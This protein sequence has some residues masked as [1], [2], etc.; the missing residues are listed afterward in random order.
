M[1]ASPK[2]AARSSF[3]V[4]ART[5]IIQQFPPGQ[6]TRY[7]IVGLVNTAFGYGIYAALTALLTPHIPFAYMAAS[8]VSSL[9][10]ITFAFFTYKLFIFKTTGNYLR[11]WFRC[12]IVYGSSILV[13]TLLLPFLVLAVRLLT[14]AHTS[15][16]YIAG[17]LLTGANVF[18]SFLGHKHFSFAPTVER[19]V[20]P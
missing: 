2:L 5:T 8:L 12:V 7:L 20:Q 15:A 19:N 18:T 17:A 4:R 16:P 11:E 13:G 1:P 9:I 14:P 10:N 6:F 3:L